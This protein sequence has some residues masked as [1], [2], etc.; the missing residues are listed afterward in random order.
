ME[1]VF[2]GTSLA[3]YANMVDGVVRATQIDTVSVLLLVAVEHLLPR[4][5]VIGYL[6][7][8]RHLTVSVN[9][10]EPVFYDYT[11]NV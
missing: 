1:E 5:A 2:A 7:D 10:A 11:F 4:F 9:S 8:Y 6:D 3:A